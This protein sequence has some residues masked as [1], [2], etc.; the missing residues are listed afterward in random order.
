[1]FKWQ[2]P[3]YVT[4]QRPKPRLLPQITSGPWPLSTTQSREPLFQNSSSLAPPWSQGIFPC[5]GLIHR[6]PTAD[7]T[8]SADNRTAP[9]RPQ[10][11]PPPQLRSSAR[12]LLIL[13]HPHISLLLESLICFTCRPDH[14]FL[15]SSPS[16]P[17]FSLTAFVAS[18]VT[19]AS[20]R[21]LSPLPPFHLRSPPKRGFQPQDP[22]R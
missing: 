18:S 14:F 5:L 9:D 19:M 6:C 8:H 12:F 10:S 2:V 15:Y 17:F 11:P 4:S 21:T 20:P 13:S 1:M 22:V 3:A 7:A 16:Y